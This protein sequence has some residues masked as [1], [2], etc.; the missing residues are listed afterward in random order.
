M[1]RL[2]EL[3]AALCPNGVEYTRLRDIAEMQR[4]KPITKN[5]IT[6]GMIP[7]I[8]GGKEPAYYCNI[9]NREGDIITVAGSGVNAGY[10]L[11]WT[12]PVFV[13]DA[14]SIKGKEDVLTKYL[15]YCLEN[16]Q[17]EIHATKKGGGVPHVHI[18][19][20][21]NF[22]IPVP[23]LP[24]QEEIV[25]ILDTFTE[26][27]AELTKRRQ[28]YQC[29]RDKLLT[30]DTVDTA[31]KWMTLD[32]VALVFGRGK[33]KHRPRNDSRLYG[34]NIPFI[35][36][37]DIKNAS[38]IIHEYQQTYSEFGLEQSKLWPKGTLCITIAAN[39]AETSILGFDACFPD[40]VI[41]FIPDP[42][43]TTSEYVE[44]LLST[45]KQKL[46]SKRTGSAQDNLNMAAFEN[47][48]LPF[49]SPQEQAR[50][51]AILDRFD[52]LCNDLTSG[53][54]AEIEARRKQYEYYR[55][56]LLTFKEAV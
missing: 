3:M 48:R 50:I 17:E 11:Y 29:Y 32:E 24:V 30:F 55:D 6:A 41:G 1:S 2:E 56:K 26:L 21:E 45:Y 9:S 25:R 20:I 16:M 44:Y 54:P 39:I 14:F 43:K 4:G 52:A 12:Q 31:I 13:S 37:G 22:K 36:T 23:P 42:Q 34:G 53:L 18:S 15:Y 7:V 40:S 49:P 51:V 28:Q 19:S 35:Q 27:T 8:S 5:A 38:H 46:Q 10:L 33:S 47:M